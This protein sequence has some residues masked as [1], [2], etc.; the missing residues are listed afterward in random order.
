MIRIKHTYLGILN[1]ST[2]LTMLVTTILLASC[3]KNEPEVKP[4]ARRTVVVY[5]VAENSLYG[6]DNMDIREIRMAMD[7]IPLDCNLVVYQDNTSLPVIKT[8][9][10]M[11][12]E[13]TWK[14]LPEQ[15]SCDS[16]VFVQ[17]IR[18]ILDE[19]P[20]SSYGLVLWSHGS[21]WVPNQQRR[22]IGIDN[23]I[24]GTTNRGDEMEITT[25]RGCLE[26][27]GVKWDYILFDACFMQSIELDYELRN[28]TDNIIA[29]P[30][31]IPGNGAPYHRIMS[32]LFLDSLA[33][34]GITQ[35]YYDTYVREGNRVVISLAKTRYM[36][37]MREA[38]S[39]IMPDLYDQES[40]PYSQAT[41]IQSYCSYNQY[42]NWKPEYYDLGSAIHHFHPTQWEQWLETAQKAIPLYLTTSTWET[43]YSTVNARFHDREHCIGASIYLPAQRYSD[44]TNYNEAIKSY[45]WYQKY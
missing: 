11:T 36:E 28:V 20:A 16:T 44:N 7:S 21:G 17:T 19:F 27:L 31:E 2:L 35:H 23:N 43:S 4:I 9:S 45:S 34:E 18:Q 38:T 8:Y 32:D 13:H 26:Q 40:W 33:A 29:S 39:Q 25:L 6:F 30:A 24:N 14:Q 12:G 41:G 37:Q 42:T 22:T 3:H 15:N 1:P 5:M 10:A